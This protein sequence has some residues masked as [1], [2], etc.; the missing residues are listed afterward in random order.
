[1]GGVRVAAR[2]ISSR[3]VRPAEAIAFFR[4]RG[5]GLAEK[6]MIRFHPGS[7]AQPFRSHFEILIDEAGI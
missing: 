5:L 3:N 4:H 2:L 6:A 7:S 1:M